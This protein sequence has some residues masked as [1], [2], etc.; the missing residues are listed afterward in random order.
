MTRS[1]SEEV[2]G[3]GASAAVGRSWWGAI[4]V[5]ACGHL[6]GDFYAVLFIPLIQDFRDAFG[7]SVMAVTILVNVNALSN[8]TLQPIM[9]HFLERFDQRRVFA[10]GLVIATVLL[11]CIG[12][13]QGPVS[14]GVLLALGGIGV[15]LFHPSGAVLASRFAGAKKGLAMSIY[16][17][18]GALGIAAGP[19][20]VALLLL[21][22]TRQSLWVF[23]PFGLVAAAAVMFIPAT[24]S[25]VTPARLPTWRS[26][27]HPDSRSVWLVFIS[28][29][30]RSLVVLAVTSFVIMYGAQRGWSNAEG[31]ILLTAFLFSCA[32]GG[33]AGGYLSDY[34]ERRR[35]MLAACFLGFVPLMAAW[36]VSFLPALVLLVLSGGILSLSTPVY[37][38]VAQEMRPERASAM[39]GVMMGFAWS[40]SVVLLI[41]FGALADWTS[42]ATALRASSLLLPVAGLVVLPL[43]AL[44]PVARQERATAV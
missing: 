35:L 33:F 8:S 19:L 17:N 40:V 7:L 11:S 10:T 21:V 16:S 4:L 5:L 25:T 22:A 14:L 20:G 28:V 6:V 13:A 24:T 26:L 38:V 41:P 9:G 32:L 34:V 43:P 1:Q 15:A 23:M 36:H 44:P 42:P 3:L 39:S 29:V 27:V 2:A 30:L 31:R 37:I 18:G 12:F